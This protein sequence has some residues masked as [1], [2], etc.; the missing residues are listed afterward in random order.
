MYFQLDEFIIYFFNVD[1]TN[2]IIS[3]IFLN[4][5]FLQSFAHHLTFN[6]SV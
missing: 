4:F 3:S 2:V 5:D 6:G 1:F